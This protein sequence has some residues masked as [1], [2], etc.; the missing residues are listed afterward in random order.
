MGESPLEK[1]DM[2]LQKFGKLVLLALAAFVAPSA[3]IAGGGLLGLLPQ[4]VAAAAAQTTASAVAAAQGWPQLT[5]GLNSEWAW[6]AMGVI[7]CAVAA[8]IVHYW[9]GGH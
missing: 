3:V 8:R 7:G 6:V 9:R 5:V 1:G 4:G 2:M